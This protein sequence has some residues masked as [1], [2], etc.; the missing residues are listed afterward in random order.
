MGRLNR[1]WGGRVSKTASTQRRTRARRTESSDA[2]HPGPATHSRQWHPGDSDAT[3]HHDSSDESLA[4]KQEDDDYSPAA[5]YGGPRSHHVDVQPDEEDSFSDESGE[6]GLPSPQDGAVT[7][8]DLDGRD[9]PLRSIE[10]YDESQFGV[11]TSP[12]LR[13]GSRIQ[14]SADGVERDRSNEDDDGDEDDDDEEG[15]ETQINMDDYYESDDDFDI[16]Y[17]VDREDIAGYRVERTKV[18]G[19]A[20]WP[21]EVARAH[22]TI[23]LRGMYPLM[24]SSWNWDLVD[25]PFVEGLF[26]PADSDKKV[27]F[28]EQSNRSRGA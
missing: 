10:D 8:D 23:A 12:S 25:H 24:P 28:Q 18:K 9:E 6:D 16:E 4:I 19:I 20:T 3:E 17:D 15:S 11:G 21:K 1:I 14:G 2:I 5:I 27:L 7:P 13:G 22:K 26:V